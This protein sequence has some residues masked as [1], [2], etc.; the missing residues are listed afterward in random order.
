MRIEDLIRQTRKRVRLLRAF[1]WS[2]WA[3]L[4]GLAF[5][6][7]YAALHVL[8]LV[9]RVP[10]ARLVWLNALAL[11]VGG[12]AGALFPV[13]TLRTLF[14]LDTK[15]QTGE[16]LLTLYDLKRRNSSSAFVP[17]LERRL[18]R[19]KVRPET[20]FHLN[21]GDTKRG[22][23]LA[24][25][26]GLTLI[27][28]WFGPALLQRAGWDQRAVAAEDTPLAAE[29]FD[30]ATLPPEL[31]D[32]FERLDR[33][34]PQLEDNV[35]SDQA[36]QNQRLIELL[37][38]VDRARDRA[39]GLSNAS[40]TIEGDPPADEKQRQQQRQQ[41]QRVQQQLQNLLNQ[42]QAAPG[43]EQGRR[44]KTKALEQALQALDKNDPTRQSIESALNAKDPGS[45]QR[46]LEGAQQQLQNRLRSDDALQA[47]RNELEGK[48]KDGGFTPEDLSQLKPSAPNKPQ[49][50]RPQN[51]QGSP[52]EDS[53][54]APDASSSAGQA[55]DKDGQ[56]APTANGER[57]LNKGDEPGLG[58]ATD[59]NGLPNQDYNPQYKD[60][61]IPQALVPSE[62]I[63]EWLSRG[64]PAESASAQPGQGAQYRLSYDR[65]QSLLERRELSPG[66]Q[67]VVRTY[68]L[69]IIGQLNETAA[70]SAT[71]EAK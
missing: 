16:L 4:A 64:V 3:V 65:V 60:A 47:A 12:L 14:R 52:P 61:R 37:Q 59:R 66:L 6:F 71:Q 18:V 45:Q 27:T 20:V 22:F 28:L 32:A 41:L 48:A 40:Q 42:M 33:P 58:S 26:L 44:Q 10:G 43:D 31:R 68:F 63:D 9:G 69:R 51:A 7:I 54:A 67:D 11:L 38:Q 36:Q 24:A 19:L 30:P 25:A 17:V 5:I 46:S 35:D 13:N 34:L 55:S 53:N 57:G 56:E 1:R 21:A 2:S 8:G 49:D 23:G 29:T 70:N 50:T 39:L 62:A 15:L